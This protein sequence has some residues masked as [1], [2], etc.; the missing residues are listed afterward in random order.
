MA[1]VSE[2]TDLLARCSNVLPGHGARQT[3]RAALNEIA[4]SLT[5]D[6]F[7]DE[8]GKGEQIEAFECEVA[9]MFGK[10]AGVFMPSG[11]MAQQIAIRIW[12]DRSGRATVAMHPS[13]HLE[14]AE[15]HGYQFLHGIHRLQFEAPEFLAERLLTTADFEALALAPGAV[16]LELPCRPLGGQLPDWDDLART[17]E[18]A[19]GHGIP[20]HL[21]GARIWSCRHFYTTS[22]DRI[23]EMFDSIYVSFYKDIGALTGCM[24]LG[25][26]DFIEAARVWQRRYGGNLFTQA[27]YVA[28]AQ[29]RLG[30]V[31]PQIDGWVERAREVARTFAQCPGVRVIPEPPHVNIFQLYLEGDAETLTE[32]HLE[33]AEDT[34][35]FLFRGLRPSTVPGIATTEVHIWENA[36]TFDASA[37]GQFMS[38]L[39]A[40]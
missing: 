3:T 13:S 17:R 19:I 24:L 36:M 1:D 6:E 34:G 9:E 2:V 32:R 22:F 16:L 11:T 29:M 10:E 21:D 25:P 23:G 37:I 8:Y 33:I 20:M 18:W 31:L 27:P 28:S 40:Q 12:C 39:L 38:R 35:T 26:D 15:H 4:E 14:F 5:G 30:R 7:P